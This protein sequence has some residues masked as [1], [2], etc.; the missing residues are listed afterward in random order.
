MTGID[1]NQLKRTNDQVY[2]RISEED[3]ISF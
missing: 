1:K 2:Y 3:Q